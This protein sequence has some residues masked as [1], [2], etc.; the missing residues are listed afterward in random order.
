MA[1]D[2]RNMHGIAVRIFHFNAVKR[3][4]AWFGDVSGLFDPLELFEPVVTGAEN[5]RKRFGGIIAH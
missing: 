2:A 3:L 1:L 4:C 5:L